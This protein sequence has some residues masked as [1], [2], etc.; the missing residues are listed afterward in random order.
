MVS[1]IPFY[2]L[3]YDTVVHLLR[4]FQYEVCYEVFDTKLKIY[5]D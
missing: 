5:H 3:F 2:S 4:G 1:G